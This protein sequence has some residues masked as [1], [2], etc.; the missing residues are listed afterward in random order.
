MIVDKFG[1]QVDLLPVSP[2][3]LVFSVLGSEEPE[4]GRGELQSA[5]APTA[6]M[7]SVS[8]A[9]VRLRGEESALDHRIASAM[10]G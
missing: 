10:N 6:E 8:L 2:G 7:D 1:P 3:M 9:R 4:H 5:Q